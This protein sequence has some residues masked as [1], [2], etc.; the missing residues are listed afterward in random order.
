[1]HNLVPTFLT[2]FT[3]ASGTWCSYL[4]EQSEAV[5]RIRSIFDR[6]RILGLGDPDP[7]TELRTSIGSGSFVKQCLKVTLTAKNE[8]FS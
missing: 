4:F 7:W 6:I 8:T 5:Y 2:Q 1:M 3:D